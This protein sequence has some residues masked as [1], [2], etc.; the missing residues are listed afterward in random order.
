MSSKTPSKRKGTPRKLS[1]TPPLK[2]FLSEDDG[3]N[4]SPS[5]GMNVTAA[6]PAQKVDDST[7]RHCDYTEH[8]DVNTS[9]NQ[10]E[11]RLN[12]LITKEC[13]GEGATELSPS[14]QKDTIQEN[15][16]QEGK[17]KNDASNEAFCSQ[18]PIVL[19]DVSKSTPEKASEASEH[20][21][22]SASLKTIQETTPTKKKRVQLV[23]GRSGKKSSPLKIKLTSSPRRSTRKSPFFTRK[24]DEGKRKG[25][26]GKSSH[27]EASERLEQLREELTLLNE[28]S[29]GITTHIFQG[30]S[31][32][33]KKGR[34]SGSASPQKEVTPRKRTPRKVGSPIMKKRKK[35][36]D[37]DLEMQKLILGS[38]DPEKLRIIESDSEMDLCLEEKAKKNNLTAKNVK[39]IL[40]HVLTNEHVVAM[41]KNTLSME[42]P[43]EAPYVPKMTRAKVKEVMQKGNVPLPL[44]LSPIKKPQK[45]K[46]FLQLSFEDDEEDDEYVP[47]NESF[48]DS[49]EDSESVASSQTS[50]LG[51]PIPR[52]RTPSTPKQQRVQLKPLGESTPKAKALVT[53][54]QEP[55]LPTETE[56]PVS[57]PK[58]A[59]EPAQPESSS[60]TLTADAQKTSTI[61][62][63]KFYTETMGPPLELPPKSKLSKG[64]KTQA[65]KSEEDTIALRTRSKLPLK[66][67]P[68][69]VI[70]SSFVAP[71]ITPDMY[72]F[73]HDDQEWTGFLTGLLKDDDPSLF[74]AV[75][76]ESMDDPE[77]NFLADE[78]E[79]DEEDYRNDQS[80]R[81]SKKELNELM[82]EVFEA[83]GGWE[84]LE[85]D[86]DKIEEEMWTQGLLQGTSC[87]VDNR[88]V[89]K[90]V[91]DGEVVKK[92]DSKKK[93]KEADK[94]PQ[95]TPEER[96]Q[97]DLQMRKHVQLL[98]QMFVLSKP[99]PDY[100]EVA[101]A[102]RKL[103]E[104]VDLFRQKSQAGALSAF[105]AL[106]LADALTVVKKEDEQVFPCVTVT[107]L[108]KK[109]GKRVF[110]P[111]ELNS[112]QMSVFVNNTVFM[113]PWL[114]PQ[115]GLFPSTVMFP[116]KVF[117]T[118]AE[119]N[120]LAL[121]EYQFNAFMKR[122]ELIRY[123]LL[124]TKS[125][126]QIRIR[127]KN[128]CAT[129]KGDNL[130]KRVKSGK[131]EPQM[132]IFYE[133]LDLTKIKPIIELDGAQ[134][135]CW[136]EKYHKIF[137]K[138]G[139]KKKRKTKLK[140]HNK[141]KAK[142]TQ[143][144][145]KNGDGENE[146]HDT[147]DIGTDSECST[148]CSSCGSSCDCT[149][150]SED[151]EMNE[152]SKDTTIS[153][154]C[155]GNPNDKGETTQ[156][157]NSQKE[158]ETAEEDPA[159]R[160]HS[161]VGYSKHKGIQ[162][163]YGTSGRSTPTSGTTTISIQADQANRNSPTQFVSI[164]KFQSSA[165]TSSCQANPTTSVP[166]SSGGASSGK[167][168]KMDPR[169]P[170]LKPIAPA[171]TGGPI[172]IVAG[173]QQ[174]GAIISTD[175][176][177]GAVIL[178]QQ[179][180]QQQRSTSPVII[181]TSP[182][183]VSQ[184]VATVNESR[185]MTVQSVSSVPTSGG[186]VIV[187]SSIVTAP[188]CSESQTLNSEVNGSEVSNVPATATTQQNSPVVGK[189][190]AEVCSQENAK[191]K[192]ITLNE[193]SHASSDI[194]VTISMPTGDTLPEPAGEGKSSNDNDIAT[195]AAPLHV[196][197][198]VSET[199]AA[200]S[201]Q[202]NDIT[203]PTSL[204]E[205]SHASSDI[206]VTISMPNLTV[207]GLS[208]SAVVQKGNNDIDNDN[209]N[210]TATSE[211]IEMAGLNN[212]SPV[213]QKDFDNDSNSPTKSAVQI[214][215]SVAGFMITPPK[216][217]LNLNEDAL[218][219]PP[220]IGNFSKLSTQKAVKM[221][222]LVSPRCRTIAPKTPEKTPTKTVSPFLKKIQKS[223]R[224][225]L[226]QQQARAI[227]PKGFIFTA[228]SVSPSKKAAHAITEKIRRGG[229][230]RN[231]PTILRR[232]S[233]LRQ[234][235]PKDPAKESFDLQVVPEGDIPDED[236]DQ[237]DDLADADAEAAS[238][239]DTMESEYVSDENQQDKENQEDAS[240]I[241]PQTKKKLTKKRTTQRKTNRVIGPPSDG[242]DDEDESPDEDDHLAQLMAASSTIGFNPQKRSSLQMSKKSKAKK[243]KEATLAM[244]MPNL[245]EADT[246]KDEKDT[247]FAQAYLTKVKETLK[248]D[249]DTY[250]KFLRTLYEFEK[251]QSSP[252]Q[253]YNS[254]RILLGNFP[255]LV[256]DF[257]GFLLPEQAVECGCFMANKEFEK[258]RIF[259]RKLE[260]CFG[261]DSSHY[262]KILKVFSRWQNK[263][264][265]NVEELKTTVK[266]LLKGQA[267]L[268]EEFSTFFM[269]ARPP[270]SQ[271]NCFEEV[272]LSDS[273]DESKMA[274]LD[275][276]EIVELPEEDTD[277]GTKRCRCNCHQN[278]QDEKLK[279]KKKHCASCCPLKIVDGR[280]YLQ[281]GSKN[282][283][284]A[285]VIF[286]H[287]PKAAPS[288]PSL[289]PPHT[290]PS[291]NSPKIAARQQNTNE[292][293]NNAKE[294]VSNSIQQA[295]RNGNV[296]SAAF[297]NIDMNLQE[298]SNE[299]GRIQNST[300]QKLNEE[301]RAVDSPVSDV[302]QSTQISE[303]SS[304]SDLLKAALRQSGI[305]PNSNSMDGQT[306]L[307]VT[308]SRLGPIMSSDI[309]LPSSAASAFTRVTSSSSSQS[310]SDV[311]PTSGSPL[312]LT[313][314]TQR[315]VEMK[316]QR[317]RKR[318]KLVTLSTTVPSHV[319]E[320]SAFSVASQASNPD[321][322]QT[323]TLDTTVQAELPVVTETLNMPE[324]LSAPEVSS[325]ASEKSSVH[326][327]PN[328]S[329]KTSGADS[330]RIVMKINLTQN[331]A[332]TTVLPHSDDSESSKDSFIWSREDDKIILETCKTEEPTDETFIKI[333]SQLS[334]RTAKQVRNRFYTLMDIFSDDG[335]CD[336][337]DIST[338][339]N[340]VSL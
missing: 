101:S 176:A 129:K 233:R 75:E 104:E 126:T 23:K 303:L 293:S 236:E 217:V 322:S 138:E 118:E 181:M 1:L 203:K 318:A 279:K 319:P 194:G 198:F 119:D 152:I 280:I 4:T 257:S 187:N 235:L 12:D 56:K 64:E 26:P 164:Q 97:L 112:H 260:V 304:D 255:D 334:S 90:M 173:P 85:Q 254:I 320:H 284:P 87:K 117:F 148:C 196:S 71:D 339:S 3:N 137:S 186:N 58:P 300:D 143:G 33:E 167:G 336:G 266:P 335:T 72:D 171:L 302:M 11:S 80:V 43:S 250:E 309:M 8:S 13:T 67:T 113:Y 175:K 185:S 301:V 262:Q 312:G 74:D 48:Q 7:E 59:A 42:D 259:L 151:E 308:P 291:Q 163:H 140:K 252:V 202:K 21:H 111:P 53:K 159:L 132:P 239:Y 155:G 183:V 331:S 215:A 204:N 136:I 160:D 161:D 22:D 49:D 84:G 108:K 69:D 82:D 36:K 276:F 73:E 232:S 224:R 44:P 93:V 89:S 16:E 66:D 122:S 290:N 251:S 141:E 51:S 205:D 277:C 62:E 124:P 193:N 337:D 180:P 157:P 220:Q 30:S 197:K 95:V 65:E 5:H 212:M 172:I 39:N 105:N 289:S 88:L 169:K 285:Q 28:E 149:S 162:I 283:R 213:K 19:P 207:E 139:S 324:K 333:A 288:P 115:S 15:M 40:H 229:L 274:A 192:A 195:A 150:G 18:T 41:M 294:D 313:S 208:K 55:S 305:E 271:M 263:G 258:V 177:P 244:L 264:K 10:V 182:Q 223:P 145:N 94:I 156:K 243:R 6:Q 249:L 256:N 317:P 128:M 209:N 50:D 218:H 144:E 61:T 60:T 38:P 25:T 77:Y 234:L 269:D 338:D 54:E 190:G 79:V 147:K 91:Q 240:K 121:G 158:T 248:N 216:R 261:R 110:D 86:D 201:S 99:I 78:E 327:N 32:S 306:Q 296:P 241:K 45:V 47:E 270:E 29:K 315:K 170:H 281:M 226:L 184:Q 286:H 125:A 123:F 134:Q 178:N 102:S 311:Q 200:V 210:A 127:T 81:V 14:Q 206:G 247:A 328:A 96:A 189:I 24:N 227:L 63:P 100:S 307:T 114:V 57:S 299:S 76:D 191:T 326:E 131:F 310:S 146:I 103:L 20:S 297:L 34:L 265:G 133:T 27:T 211:A 228:P 168:P 153:S 46:N 230:S 225:Q 295:S 314:K 323:T 31:S 92:K 214:M 106:N 237:D 287:P 325:A 330:R 107:N 135:P 83:Y 142:G 68:L 179:S 292:K 52:P 332:V 199:G 275:G 98:T 35:E 165:E 9:E 130:I 340:D 238:E 17:D 267:H 154:S 273:G 221:P 298:Q 174:M 245:I 278:A 188:P 2:R 231:M 329:E 242:S 272:N 120:L 109:R 222:Q 219:S 116:Q 268:L 253:L 321:S 37:D 282:L 246:L 166:A 70:E 316:I